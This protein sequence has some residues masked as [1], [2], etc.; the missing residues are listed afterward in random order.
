MVPP[1]RGRTAVVETLKGGAIVDATDTG[2]YTSLL[3]AAQRSNVRTGRHSAERRRPIRQEPVP[4]VA[5]VDRGIPG[6]L[7]LR[8]L[9]AEANTHAPDFTG[10]RACLTARPGAARSRPW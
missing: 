10:P 8:A 2:G 4:G 7:R 1:V 6:G 3:H 5:A 9:L